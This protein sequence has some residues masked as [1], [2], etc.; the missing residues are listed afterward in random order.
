MRKQT[1]D[2]EK[3]QNK[4]YELGNDNRSLLNE[5][6]KLK[7]LVKKLKAQRGKQ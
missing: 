5:N 1:D 2:C 7:D 6:D 4:C 3:A